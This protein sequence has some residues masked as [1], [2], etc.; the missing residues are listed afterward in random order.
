MSGVITM[1][2][3]SRLIWVAVL[4]IPPCSGR[5]NQPEADHLPEQRVL[6]EEGKDASAIAKKLLNHFGPDGLDRF[7][8]RT[9][10]QFGPLVQTGVLSEEDEQTIRRRGFSEF[11]FH[12]SAVF[13]RRYEFRFRTAPDTVFRIELNHLGELV[14]EDGEQDKSDDLQ[15][16]VTLMWSV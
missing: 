14:L 5:T 12:R 9:P 16:D 13:S 10:G 4:A 1:R 7:T 8:I 6:S 11:Y 3:R 15:S 2:R